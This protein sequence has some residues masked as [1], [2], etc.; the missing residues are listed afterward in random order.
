MYF[1]KSNKSNIFVVSFTLNPAKSE[2][3]HPFI[4]SYT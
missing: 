3:I 2:K 1:Y 4:L